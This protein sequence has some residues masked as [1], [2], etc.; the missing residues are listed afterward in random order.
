MRL[1]TEPKI[2]L[3]ALLGMALS[4]VGCAS[5]QSVE[6]VQLEPVDTVVARPQQVDANLMTHVRALAQQLT[7]DSR[8]INSSTPLAVTSF[9]GLDDL[10]S[11]NELGNQLAELLTVEMHR[12]GWTLIDYKLTG[13]IDVTEQGDYALT[14]DFERL[15]HRHPIEYLLTGVMIEQ[16]EGIQL[17]ARIVGLQSRAIVASAQRFV[18]ARDLQSPLGE[19]YSQHQVSIDPDTQ[20]LRRES[21]RP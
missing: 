7:R 1:I 21:E 3:G 19:D 20:R 16:P 18:A 14:R 8:Y 10:E 6:V 4:L 17:T 2:T 11:T 13:A 12:L 5:P 15:Q 9:V